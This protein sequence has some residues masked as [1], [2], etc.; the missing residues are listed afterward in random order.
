LFSD[1]SRSL[2]DSSS[3]TEITLHDEIKLIELYL[4][5]ECIRLP[6]IKYEIKRQSGLQEYVIHIPAMILQPLVENAVN[7]G[8]ANKTEDCYL[9][10][11]FTESNN[12]LVVEIEDNGIGRVKSAEINLRKN[13]KYQSFSMQAIEDRISIL[14]KNRKKPIEQ[15]V[16]DKYDAN[17]K[18]CGTFVKLSIP[19]EDYD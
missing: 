1:L 14:N 10:L 19:I 3:L 6:K 15:A 9:E 11:R 17:N 2:L 5:L 8:F 16:I 4:Q 12:T 7:H 13:K 18:P